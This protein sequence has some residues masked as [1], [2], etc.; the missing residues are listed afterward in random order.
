MFFY[1]QSDNISQDERAAINAL[2]KNDKLN[3]KKADKG[4]NT[5]I[6]D[7]TQKMEEGLKQLSDDKFYKP[8]SSPIVLDTARKVKE[9]VNNLHCA[10]H[11]DYKWLNDCQKQPRIPEFYT[12]TKIHK[13]IPV[14]R[15]IVSGS[16]G[17]TERISSF[18]DSLLQ[19]IA[20]K[21]KSYLKDTTDFINFIE[22]TLMTNNTLLGTLDV[23]SLYTNIPQVEGINIVC[24]QYESHYES[25]PPIPVTYLRELMR[26]ILEENSFKFNER[27]FLQTHGIAMG[28]KMA[29]AFSVIYMA[30]FEERLLEASPIKPLVWK[31]FI[32]DI[33]S[34]W[35]I[36]AEEVKTFVDFANSFHP[37]IK[38]TYELSSSNAVFLDTDVFKGPRFSTLNI[39]DIRTHFIPTE[40]FQYT[41]F[42]TCHPLNTKKG[43][44]KGEA[45][46]LLRTNSVKENFENV[47]RDFEQRL[48][49]RGY[50]VMLVKNILRE[51]RFENRKEA[52]RSKPK[53]R[54]EILPFVT[55]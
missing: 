1:P 39:L 22:N 18:V 11:I 35:D 34:L 20:I 27:H 26:L 46:R 31:R 5:V 41:H 33:F 44:I 25:K 6:L 15:P 29:V 2:K 13:K 48:Y 52:L 9:V 30:D 19:P 10:G 53:Q 47:K 23:S 32:D 54:N 45:L 51:V 36:P 4:T 50:P 24:R 7:A 42:S 28:T 17:P 40:T 49:N 55:T 8:R 21:Q 38:F 12:L 16:S 14:G 3:L 37:T 43:F